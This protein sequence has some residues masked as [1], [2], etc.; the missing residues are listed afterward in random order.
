MMCM[1]L[2]F[3]VPL[4]TSLSR[5]TAPLENPEPAIEKQPNSCF[6]SAI[7]FKETFD[8]YGI[9]SR[10]VTVL[11]KRPKEDPNQIYGH[12]FVE[13][14]YPKNSTNLWLYDNTGSWKA[15]Y[16][17]KDNPDELS[18]KVFDDNQEDFVIYKAKFFGDN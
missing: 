16:S 11:Y 5:D 2:F 18:K 14:I 6:I 10:I 7:I 15:D 8:R 4:N 3:T 17:L 12:S 9:W 1:V 13:Y